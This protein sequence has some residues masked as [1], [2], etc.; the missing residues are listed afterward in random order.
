[1]VYTDTEGG[2]HSTLNPADVAHLKHKITRYMRTDFARLNYSLTVEMALRVIR[3]EGIGERVVYFYVVGTDEKLIGIVP[4]RRLLTSQANVPIEKLMVTDL[5]TVNHRATV[6]EVCEMFVKHKL[7]A[8]PVIDDEGH[9][10]G[11]IDAGLFTEE[12]LT[13][14]ERYQF[15]DI[16]QM[17]GYGIEHVKG[18]SAFNV[19]RYRFPWLLAT[20]ASGITCAVLTGFYEV[21]LAQTIVLAFFLTLVLALGESVS[22]QSMTVALQSLHRGEPTFADYIG[23]LRKEITATALLGATCGLIAALIAFGWRGE[24]IAALVV[25]LSI[26]L[27]VV[28]AGGIGLSIPTLLHAVHEQ[29]KIAS[30]PL[31]LATAD[32]C[33]ILIYFNMARVLL[34]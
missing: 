15:D 20:L 4:T 5:I 8:L 13:F 24:P 25:G 29:S 3:R 17:I 34:G 21:T 12:E 28:V 6:L 32:V 10:L 31:T 11:V 22:I 14:G 16:F 18:K 19:F 1:M 27:A 30:G 33:T 7:L 2:I 26:S 9:M 23:Q